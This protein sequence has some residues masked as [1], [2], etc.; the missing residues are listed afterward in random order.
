MVKDRLSGAL[1]V[2]LE[3]AQQSQLKL[4]LLQDIHTQNIDDLTEHTHCPKKVLVYTH[5][6]FPWQCNW[7]SPP[8]Q[9]SNKVDSFSLKTGVCVYTPPYK[10]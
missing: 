8:T 6:Q 10:P 2:F 4:P 9:L 7:G 5:I 1:Q 3:P